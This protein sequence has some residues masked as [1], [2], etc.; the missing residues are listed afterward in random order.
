MA[1]FAYTHF[2]YT[3]F[4]REIW[5][6]G[7]EE[8]VP[9]VV[10]DMHTHMWSEAHAGD[11]AGAAGEGLR[12]DFDYQSHLEWAANLYP[13][14]E[15]HLLVLGTPV[16]G[17]DAEGHNNWLAQELAADPASAINMM[18]TPDMTAEYIAAQVEKHQF[19]GLKPYRTF[20]ADP[21]NCSIA[22]F[23]PEHQIEAAH[24]MGL[25]IT[26][27]LSKF[28]GA[29]DSDNQADLE[30]YT[31]EYGGAQWILAHC[32]RAFNSFMMEGSI[33]F[34]CGLPNIW[35]D[36]SAVNDVY[37][38][39]LLMKHEDRKRVMFGSDNIVAGCM[40]GKYITYGRAWEFFGGLGDLP[41][42]TPWPTFVIYEQLKQEC[43]VADMLGLT[44]GEIEDHFSGNGRRFIEMIREGR[45]RS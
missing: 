11:A 25:A 22:D 41:H 15:F 37:S 32:A 18:V 2:E 9:P 10:Y 16:V 27:H 4:D 24:H 28:T 3:D 7:L 5:E 44:P 34:L 13:G 39:Y 29:A 14:R 26:M 35:Y 17:M 20:A 12:Q 19:L 42:C 33:E 45:S 36:T 23:L 8:F 1:D 21:A 38:H 30:R 31:R 40:R 43:Q 6:A